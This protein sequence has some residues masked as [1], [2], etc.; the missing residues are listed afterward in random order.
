MCLSLQKPK[1]TPTPSIQV[2]PLC[3]CSLSHSLSH[4]FF[5]LSTASYFL[6]RLHHHHHHLLLPLLL[7]LFL[8]LNPFFYL[9]LNSAPATPPYLLFIIASSLNHTPLLPPW[10]NTTRRTLTLFTQKKL[11]IDLGRSYLHR[12]RVVYRIGTRREYTGC[13]RERDDGRNEKEIVS[14]RRT[15]E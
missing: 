9:T 7:L 5:Y 2:V 12:I 4:S 3:T 8:L 15:P 13:K 11:I 6:V 14:K 10:H 1:D